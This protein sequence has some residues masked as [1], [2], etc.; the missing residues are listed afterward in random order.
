MYLKKICISGGKKIIYPHQDKST[1]PTFFQAI[2]K[3]HLCVDFHQGLSTWHNF[4]FDWKTLRGKRRPWGDYPPKI[5]TASK[6]TPYQKN[7][8]I[9]QAIIFGKFLTSLK[10]NNQFE[11]VFFSGQFAPS[12]SRKAAGKFGVSLRWIQSSL[13]S[14]PSK[15]AGTW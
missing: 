2:Q 9:L 13:S 7:Q 11:P 5:S 3:M 10:T 4:C 1:L 12:H 8:Y 15:N 6:M 14:W